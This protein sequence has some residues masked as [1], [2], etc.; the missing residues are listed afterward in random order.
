MNSSAIN[1]TGL[2]LEESVSDGRKGDGIDVTL[3]GN[4]KLTVNRF[5][6]GLA[7]KI[8]MC[9]QK[10]QDGQCGNFNG[11]VSDD[12]QDFILSRT[13]PLHGKKKLPWREH[14]HLAAAKKKH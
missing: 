12:T 4:M 8:T 9:A 11:D 1:I 7:V 3:P 14:R 13:K 2:D 10:W 6:R 5:E